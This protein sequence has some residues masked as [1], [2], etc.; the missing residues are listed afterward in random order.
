MSETHRDIRLAGTV[1]ER[2]R[3]FCAFFS[4]RDEE[5]QAL[6]PFLTLLGARMPELVTGAILVESV[7]SWPGVASARR[8]FI[9][10]RVQTNSLQM[11]LRSGVQEP[12]TQR[13]PLHWRFQERRQGLREQRS[14]S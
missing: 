7:F 13:P 14:R 8:L 11:P 9:G 5:Y 12:K 1:L 6:L 2:K 3:H 4:T 10:L